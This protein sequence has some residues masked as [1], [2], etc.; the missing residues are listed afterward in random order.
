MGFI[1]LKRNCLGSY[2]LWYSGKVRRGCSAFLVRKQQGCMDLCLQRDDQTTES[3]SVRQRAQ[4]SA[5]DI[6][7]GICYRL[8]HQEEALH[9]AFKQLKKPHICRRLVLVLSHFNI[10]WKNNTTV[11]K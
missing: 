9:D 4:T 11:H 10:Y 3:L 7:M 5:G 6:V 8:P 2:K 1:Y